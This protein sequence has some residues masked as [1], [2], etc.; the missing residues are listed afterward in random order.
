MDER[1][2]TR[3]CLP[4]PDDSREVGGAGAEKRMRGD[5]KW[6]VSTPSLEEQIVRQEMKNWQEHFS[7]PF[8]TT[9]HDL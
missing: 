6:K 5:K 7:P 9:N 8:A 4:Q 3:P 2:N 1:S